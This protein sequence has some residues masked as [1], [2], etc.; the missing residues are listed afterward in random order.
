MREGDFFSCV[1]IISFTF[2]FLFF[3]VFYPLLLLKHYKPLK[4][5]GFFVLQL[6]KKF[7]GSALF[8]LLLRAGQ[9]S[10]QFRDVPVYSQ[11]TESL[12]FTPV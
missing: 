4:L 12:D 3:D 8:P 9:A 10:G 6:C 5:L 11:I 7:H 1:C 2:S